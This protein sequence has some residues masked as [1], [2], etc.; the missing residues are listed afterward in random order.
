MET[1]LAACETPL[2]KAIVEVTYSTGVRI[3]ELVSIRVDDI[4]FSSPGVIRI[5]A[6][7]GNKDRNVF[8]GSK[9]TPQSRR[10]SEIEGRDSF[11]APARIEPRQWHTWWGR[12]YVNGT[13]QP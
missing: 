9:M 11:Q 12:Y 4:T 7:K 3:S 5:V 13:Q 2:E 6:G 10:I 1:L 8:F